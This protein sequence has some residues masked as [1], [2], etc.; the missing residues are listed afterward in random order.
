ML[1]HPPPP[2]CQE[3]LMEI[4]LASEFLDNNLIHE[5]RSNCMGSHYDLEKLQKLR[6]KVNIEYSNY[7]RN[8]VAEIMIAANKL[9]EMGIDYE[10]DIKG[11][12]DIKNYDT[13]QV[14]KMKL[15]NIELNI[16]NLIS[17]LHNAAATN[18]KTILKIN[19]QFLEDFPELKKAISAVNEANNLVMDYLIHYA[20]NLLKFKLINNYLEFYKIKEKISKLRDALKE[21]LNNFEDMGKRSYLN[22]EISEINMERKRLEEELR[23]LYREIERNKEVSMEII[24]KCLNLLEEVDKVIKFER[25]VER[26]YLVIDVFFDIIKEKASYKNVIK[27]S[28]IYLKDKYGRVVFEIISKLNNAFI[29]DR[30][31]NVLKIRNFK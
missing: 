27:P 30:E 2:I 29:Y 12:F 9:K 31:L 15:D 20:P 5:I 22:V 26:I 13:F 1:S 17:K 21:T 3:L 7:L 4:D 16:S 6:E 18:I 14:M 10:I 11:H 23:S 19:V 24:G 28:D 8:K 25:I